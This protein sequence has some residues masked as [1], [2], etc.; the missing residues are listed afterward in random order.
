MFS[1]ETDILRKLRFI[2]KQK[3]EFAVDVGQV[4]KAI[5]DNNTDEIY[6][7][8]ATVII[9]AY[10]LGQKLEIDSSALDE[11]VQTRLE[12]IIK[13]EPEADKLYGDHSL[14]MRYLK[15][16]KGER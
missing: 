13:R 2:E 9:L 6:N 3:E 14:L 1:H 12:Q 4:Y 5:A 15:S 7:T 16:K 10:V 8:L 11:T